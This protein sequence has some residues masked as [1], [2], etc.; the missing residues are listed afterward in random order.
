MASDS[1]RDPNVVRAVTGQMWIARHLERIG[2]HVTNIAER[3]YFM[4]KGEKLPKN[5]EE[6]AKRHP[7]PSA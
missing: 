2:D 6:A 5:E 4:D 3:V 7:V 1:T